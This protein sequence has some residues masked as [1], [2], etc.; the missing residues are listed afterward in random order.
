MLIVWRSCGLI[1]WSAVF[2]LAQLPLP[3]PAS[4]KPSDNQVAVRLEKEWLQAN[5]PRLVS[6]GAYLVAKDSRRELIP[7]LIEQMDLSRIDPAAAGP[8]R[9]LK[10][11]TAAL[12]AVL[13]ALIRLEAQV[14][15]DRL[16]KLHGPDFV[17]QKLILLAR[18]PGNTAALQEILESSMVITVEFVVAADLLAAHPPPGFTNSIIERFQPNAT[19]HVTDG[20]TSGNR[21]P[22]GCGCAGDFGPPSPVDQSWPKIRSYGLSLEGGTLFAPGVHAGYYWTVEEGQSPPSLANRACIA[23]CHEKEMLQ[24]LLASLAQMT[25][26]EFPL[27]HDANVEI[28]Y[29]SPASYRTQLRAILKGLDSDFERVV[30]AY[31][32][33]GFLTPAEAEPLKLQ[34]W[35]V[36]ERQGKPAR[37]LPRPPV[38]RWLKVGY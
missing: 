32:R 1:L 3:D 27:H 24:G 28:R 12:A 15:P 2:G 5:D 16:M 29:Q 18:S 20:K 21:G 8:D 6:W 31:L 13:D 14:P 19:I 38:F 34:V 30:S 9:Y 33:Q 10:G 26:K 17:A 35:I 23:P 4:Y 11:R 7:D 37:P 36:D 22:G 25:P